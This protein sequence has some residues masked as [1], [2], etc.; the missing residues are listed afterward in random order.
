M[1]SLL[2]SM[3]SKKNRGC[4]SQ[5]GLGSS[6]LCGRAIWTIWCVHPG[7][8]TFYSCY[9]WRW[10]RCFLR[11]IFIF[12][13]LENIIMKE[14]TKARKIPTP[15]KMKVP[16]ILVSASF[17]LLTCVNTK[18]FS[19]WL[20]RIELPVRN[21]SPSIWPISPWY[22]Q[23]FPQIA[24]SW[25]H[26]WSF[27]CVENLKNPCLFQLKVEKETFLLFW[28]TIVMKLSFNLSPTLFT[29]Q[30]SSGAEINKS[31]YFRVKL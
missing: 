27:L 18:Y 25:C 22:S 15:R 2:P 17:E 7:K 20:N 5:W 3:T 1:F 24:A 12:S 29:L 4:W 30:K 19:V 21:F 23:W 13:F 11:Q 6:V 16:P 8:V 9:Y 31:S 26:H 14:L 10:W 28:I